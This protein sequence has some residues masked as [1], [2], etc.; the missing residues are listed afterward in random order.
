MH[1][2]GPG[3]GMRTNPT[4]GLG[5]PKD[6]VDCKTTS[7]QREIN[8]SLPPFGENN[9]KID[10]EKINDTSNFE[11]KTFEATLNSRGQFS[12]DPIHGKI[13]AGDCEA[14]ELFE[15]SNCEILT[16]DHKIVKETK[17][18]A[19]CEELDLFID[20]CCHQY[21]NLLFYFKFM[22]CKIHNIYGTE[23]LRAYK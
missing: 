9:S 19:K 13:L 14:S 20:Y 3:D 4:D 7:P 6:R 5:T 10:P 1:H 17:A 21:D 18:I 16:K 22:F 8:T 12:E 15:D 23:N 11:Q 2:S